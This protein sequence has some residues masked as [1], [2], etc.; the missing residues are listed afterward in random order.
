MGNFMYS[1]YVENA[2]QLFMLNLFLWH[3]FLGWNT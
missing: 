1:L 3:M 2:T